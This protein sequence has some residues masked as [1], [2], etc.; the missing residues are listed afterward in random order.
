MKNVIVT[1]GEI[2]LGIILFGLIFG[3]TTGSLRS[4]AQS[5]FSDVT[6]EMQQ[7]TTTIP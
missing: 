7:M 6:T 5:I 1:V 3:A 2:L 4:E